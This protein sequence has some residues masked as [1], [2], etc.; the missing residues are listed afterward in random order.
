MVGR[1]TTS[2]I[3]RLSVELFVRDGVEILRDVELTIER[4]QS[5]AILGANGSGKTSLVRIPAGVE[6][7]SR[8]RIEGLGERF[9][10]VD[11]RVLRK[12]IGFVGVA[13]GDRFPAQ[14]DALS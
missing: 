11:R 9:G 1:M 6:G 2:T 4:G 5:W 10:G 3:A 12:R 14:G 7:P 8:G 13:F